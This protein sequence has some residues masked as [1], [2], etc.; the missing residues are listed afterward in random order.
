MTTLH[1]I[2][3]VMS[4]LRLDAHTHMNLYAWVDSFTLLTLRYGETVKKISKARQAKINRT[5]CKQITDEE[6]LTIATLHPPYSSIALNDGI[7]TFTNLVQLLAQNVAS[8]KKY[9]PGDN[10]RIR[11][12][13]RTRALKYQQISAIANQ[14]IKG[15]R[16]PSKRQKVYQSSQRA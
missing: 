6:K 14:G 15:K 8:L 10:E 2:R 12:Y 7:F 16:P 13:L 9:H 3:E 5:V 1:I 4:L 11:K